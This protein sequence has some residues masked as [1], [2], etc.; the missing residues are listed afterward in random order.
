MFSQG[1]FQIE[2]MQD[3]F[4]TGPDDDDSSIFLI[5]GNLIF[6]PTYPV[7]I[8]QIH[9]QFQ[10]N[11]V[12]HR[13]IQKTTRNL[14]HHE[15]E[16]LSQ[17]K[18]AQ[19]FTHRTYSFPFELALPSSLPES[20]EAENAQIE[21]GFK[22]VAETPLFQMNFKAEKSLHISKTPNPL[23]SDSF[24]T[25]SQ[26]V[27]KDVIS[28]D[29]SI[30]DHHLNPGKVVPVHIHHI[31][32]YRKVHVVGV[33]VI[34]GEI[35]LYRVPDLN[36]PN[37]ITTVESRKSVHT[38]SNY[39]SC[40]GTEQQVIRIRIPNISRRLHCDAS[41]EY[42]EVSHRLYAKIELEVNGI[43]TSMVTS[44]PILIASD[45]NVKS[46]SDSSVIEQLPNYFDITADRPP[47]YS[48][49]IVSHTEDL[50]PRYSSRYSSVA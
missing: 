44:L 32:L 30:P 26:G 29:V 7:K 17:N 5:K 22:A 27:W 2:L 18:D 9:L 10:G 38:V 45:Q 36:D 47:Q 41:S 42:I 20:L 6:V 24:N 23:I 3:H 43:Y 16:F 11:L 34:L 1:I 33:E 48:H 19:L 21:Y 8:H 25:K 15:W 28:Y 39:F 50:P 35:T 4:I 40:D 14:V 31:P 13:G 46:D 49:H 37:N 12:L